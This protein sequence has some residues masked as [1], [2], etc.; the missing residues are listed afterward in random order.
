MARDFPHCKIH[1]GG[2]TNAPGPRSCIGNF[3][4]MSR[5][6]ITFQVFKSLCKN[7]LFAIRLSANIA[8]VTP[9]KLQ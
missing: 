3:T 8:T 5:Q 7:K 6:P 4:R 9:F 2:T 1:H